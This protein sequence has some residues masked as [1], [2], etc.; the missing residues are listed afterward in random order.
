M[1]GLHIIVKIVN[2]LKWS[3]VNVVAKKEEYGDM[4]VILK[5]QI[6]MNMMNV[7][8]KK[9]KNRQNNSVSGHLR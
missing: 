6:S 5:N 9:S 1:I 4:F 2:T 3:S 7:T 8:L